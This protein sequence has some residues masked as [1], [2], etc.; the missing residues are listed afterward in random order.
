[1][2]T[3]SKIELIEKINSIKG[4]SMVSIDIVSEPRMR[5]TDNP[6]LG[7]TKSVTLSGV[8][9]FNYENSV[10]NQL[11]RENKERDFESQSRSWGTHEGNL[12]THKGEY[13]LSIKVQNSSQPVYIYEGH[14]LE[15]A[16][17]EPFLYESRKPHTQENVEKEIVVRDVKIS[18][19]KSFRAF[20][21]E[22]LVV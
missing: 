8:I 2:K 4:A 9:N 21:D 13:Y 20:G 7:A 22:Y 15:K 16:A 11:E 3:I 14:Q 17:V 5:K 1:M 19:I 12:I 6:Y 10:N 18:N